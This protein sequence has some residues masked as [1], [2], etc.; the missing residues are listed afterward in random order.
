MSTPREFCAWK[1]WH[2]KKLHALYGGE[3]LFNIHLHTHKR[4]LALTTQRCVFP[5]CLAVELIC[6]VWS[7]DIRHSFLELVKRNLGVLVLVAFLQDFLETEKPQAWVEQIQEGDTFNSW[8]I[9][10]A[11]ECD[12]LQ[13]VSPAVWK[14]SGF[15]AAFLIWKKKKNSA[16]PSSWMNRAVHKRTP[17]GNTFWTKTPNLKTSKK[18]VNQILATRA[19]PFATVLPL[20]GGGVTLWLP[21][22]HFHGGKS[23]KEAGVEA[24]PR[25]FFSRQQMTNWENVAIISIHVRIST[26]I[27]A[28]QGTLTPRP[29]RRH[30]AVRH[31]I[32]LETT[33]LSVRLFVCEHPNWQ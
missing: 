1:N 4:F 18:K 5:G 16:G 8:W 25:V 26:G 9:I 15:R 10:C 32:M 27:S 11:S 20:G 19:K 13:S 33:V 28:M 14:R 29:R 22:D 6:C 30:D 12:G 7:L 24:K 21:V 23:L 31:V 17:K 3:R 2:C